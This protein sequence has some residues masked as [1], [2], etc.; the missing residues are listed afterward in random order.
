VGALIA[1]QGGSDTKSLYIG[2]NVGVFRLFG[3]NPT[4]DA[5][6]AGG[7][8]GPMVRIQTGQ[9]DCDTPALRKE[10][11]NIW[12]EVNSDTAVFSVQVT[13]DVGAS[14]TQS[15]GVNSGAGSILGTTVLSATVLGE[16]GGKQY[17][18]VPARVNPSLDGKNFQFS[19]Q[20][21]SATSGYEFL[22]LELDFVEE[23]FN[24]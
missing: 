10:L 11:H 9:V 4:A 12:V 5:V 22:G 24:I 14:S 17:Q 2:D 15:Q 7:T 21:Q 6:A 23:A 8:A 18:A 13:S 3:G 1:W 19:F 16:V 20:E